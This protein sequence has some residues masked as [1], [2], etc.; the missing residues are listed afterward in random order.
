MNN[1][2]ATSVPV[3]SVQQEPDRSVIHIDSRERNILECPK[4]NPFSIYMNDGTT[5]LVC[6]RDLITNN[7]HNDPYL[8]LQIS[9]YN[10]SVYENQLNR[11]VHFKLVRVHKDNSCAYYK[12]TDMDTMIRLRDVNKVTFNI[13]RPNGKL[14]YS[15]VDDI[16]EANSLSEENRLEFLED[17]SG[18][19][20]RNVE[21]LETSPDYVEVG[22]LVTVFEK[23]VESGAEAKVLTVDRVKNRVVIEHID[24][25]YT[26]KNARIL[27]NKF[28]ISISLEII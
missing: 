11:E 25:S 19:K 13:L 6:V 1:V 10:K 3:T 18:L 16:R 26:S 28:Q 22:D 27:L 5:C 2:Q 4:S 12:N 9:E 15:Y 24:D 8:L 20:D 23:D 7:I 17:N 14:L 21:I